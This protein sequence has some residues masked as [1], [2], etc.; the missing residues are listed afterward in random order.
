M[1]AITEIKIK[2]NDKEIVLTSD[3]ARQIKKELDDLF[4]NDS[5]DS[6]KQIKRMYEDAID[7]RKKI[8]PERE[9]PPITSPFWDERPVYPPLPLTE[10]PPYWKY[11]E[12]YCGDTCQSGNIGKKSTTLEINL[13]NK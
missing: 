13:N 11:Y 9:Y 8:P 4:K 12:V 3:E 1:I 2:L 6:L 5:K 10:R 7:T